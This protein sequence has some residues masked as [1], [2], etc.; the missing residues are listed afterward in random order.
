MCSRRGTCASDPPDGFVLVEN[1][2]PSLESMTLSPQLFETEHPGVDTQG[3]GYRNP[4]STKERG[5]SWRQRSGSPNLCAHRKKE[6]HSRF[7]RPAM[8][9]Q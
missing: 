5:E 4:E 6:L 3:G 7:Q 8:A 2:F 1:S 9:T